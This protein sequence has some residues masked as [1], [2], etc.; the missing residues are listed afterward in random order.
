MVVIICYIGFT[1]SFISCVNLAAITSAVEGCKHYHYNISTKAIEQ[2]V[3]T[4]AVSHSSPLLTRSQLVSCCAVSS[5]TWLTLFQSLSMDSGDNVAQLTWSL[6]HRYYRG[7]DVNNIEVCTSPL[8]TSPRLLTLSI[9]HC[10][11]VSSASVVAHHT[12]LQFFENLII[13]WLPRLLSC[14]ESYPFSVIA[15]IKQG[16]VLAPV[17]FNLFW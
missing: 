17:I 4:V 8:L 9:D 11:G 14:Y 13:V 7:N 5:H 16:C 15:G 1:V 10:Y 3:E 6:W 2:Y 12:F